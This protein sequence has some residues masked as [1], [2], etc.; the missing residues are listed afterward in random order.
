MFSQVI[1]KYRSRF[2]I[3]SEKAY[4]YLRNKTERKKVIF[5]RLTQIGNFR[6][7]NS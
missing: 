4:C 7:G 3:V 1:A 5:L 6:K 2:D